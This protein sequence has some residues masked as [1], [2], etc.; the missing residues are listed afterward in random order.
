M[1]WIETTSVIYKVHFHYLYF[2]LFYF[3]H[4]QVIFFFS[5]VESP[6]FISS[7][8]NFKCNFTF[9]FLYDALK[10]ILNIEY[11]IWSIREFNFVIPCWRI[12]L[13]CIIFVWLFRLEIIYVWNIF[14]HIRSSLLTIFFF[15][16]ISFNFIV[17]LFF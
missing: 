5:G 15:F 2:D 17:S 4:F 12:Y 13:K 11:R 6:R 7:S 1:S 16:F 9:N 3:K 14:F 8:F 10:I